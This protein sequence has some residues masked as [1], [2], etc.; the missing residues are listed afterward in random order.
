[1][2]TVLRV[3]L[4]KSGRLHDGSV[5]LIKECGIDLNGRAKRSLR[6]AAS[7]FPMEIL[8]LRDDDIP[9]FVADGT[10]DIGIVG[11]NVL[12]EKGD[13]RLEIVKRL[14]FS[15]CRLSLAVPKRMAYTSA[16]D[17]E[18]LNIATS[19]P[20]LL[21]SYLAEK[22]ISAQLHELSG[23]VEIAPGLN[24]AEAICDLVSTGSTLESHG[25]K[26][27][28]VVLRSEAVLIGRTNLE[29]DKRAL[30]NRL[31]FRID[32]VQKAKRT[33][34]ILLNAPASSVD[35]ITRI[36]PKR[37]SPTVIPLAREE[38]ATEDW[39]AIHSVVDEDMFW[40]RIE[41]LKASGAQDILVLPIEK[42]IA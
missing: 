25:L 39:V 28:E 34:Y 20:T 37:K 21:G 23:S 38:G 15:K 29:D 35:A 11:E 41:D 4:Q 42:L 36:M 26:E 33:K 6:F 1:M 24:L 18:G 9:G 19:Y 17:L 3:A 2:S 40:E 31:L 14:G 7:N 13:A 12:L 22:G 10:V 16:Q 8:Y 30:L 5:D 27:V 32:A